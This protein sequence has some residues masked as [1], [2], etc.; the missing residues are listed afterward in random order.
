MQQIAEEQGPLQEQVSPVH[1]YLSKFYLNLFILL[2]K[3]YL[4][5]VRHM[6]FLSVAYP[7]NWG[8]TGNLTGTGK[9]SPCIFI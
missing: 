4:V 1:V 9:P 2:S 5:K 8:G 7:A 6:I 3:L